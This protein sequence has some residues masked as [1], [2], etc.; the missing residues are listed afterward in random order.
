MIR[1]CQLPELKKTGVVGVFS[2][3]CAKGIPV[4]RL[5]AVLSL[6]LLTGCSGLVAKSP[7]DDVST[8]EV[9]EQEAPAE[10]LICPEPDPC[11][12]P[13]CPKPKVKPVKAPRVAEK[14]VIGEVEEVVLRPDNL[15]FPARI[16]TGATTTSLH[17]TDVQRFERDGER[18]VRYTIY[19]PKTGEA[20]PKE[21]KQVRR[22]RI[23]NA[24]QGF[25][26]RRVVMMTLSI[27]D[28]TRQIEVSLIDR[29]QLDYPLLIGRNFLIDLLLVDVSQRYIANSK[30]L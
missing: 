23:K 30:P 14:K 12:C 7:V 28:I 1:G 15:T 5:A 13:V 25:D 16:D 3:A 9:E 4:V 17:A 2:G 29:S 20:I 22:I 8:T 11:I 19:D 6:V 21:G 24:E 27:G 26:R 18:W 10:E